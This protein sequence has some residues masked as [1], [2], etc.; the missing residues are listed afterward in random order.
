M[1]FNNSSS[2][3]KAI[4]E[5]VN[6]VLDEAIESLRWARLHFHEPRASESLRDLEG[7]LGYLAMAMA[8]QND[9]AV[10]EASQALGLAQ[11]RSIREQDSMRR[12]WEEM[13]WSH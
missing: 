3:A 9:G 8:W 4:E 11:G 6:G 5:D 12:M 10:A 7:K 1:M 2:N 13:W